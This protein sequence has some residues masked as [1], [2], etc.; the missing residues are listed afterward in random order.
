MK[1]RVEI[2]GLGE[3]QRRLRRVPIDLR[4]AAPLALYGAAAL[5]ASVAEGSAPEDA[6]DLKAGI[7]A[8]RTATG[9]EI[10]SQ[11]PHSIH[12][13]YGTAD[14]PAQP[15]LRPAM[16]TAGKLSII[17]A[18]KLVKRAVGA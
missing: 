2:R 14:Q 15:F 3:A 13:E 9:A 16:D 17:G 4:D 12:V 5:V 11:E 18:A 7:G 6:G 8:R 1:A 10:E